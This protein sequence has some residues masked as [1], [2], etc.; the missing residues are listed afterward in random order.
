[1]ARTFL[2]P[3]DFNKNE[4]RN[5]R[6]QNLSTAPSSPVTGQL[7][8]DTDDNKG[9]MWNGTSW[10]SMLEGGAAGI[11]TTIVDVKGDLIVATGADAVSRL[12]VGAD[13][14]I[15]MADAAAG[16]G[17]KWVAPTTTPAAIG[18]QAGGTGDTFTR[19]DHVHATGASTPSTQAF[20]D[21]AAIGSGPA[22]SMTDHKHA[23][24][25]HALATH[26]EMLATADLT[27][28]PRVAALS[29]SS[30]LITNLLDPVSAQD[31]ATKNYVDAI[32][33]GLNWKDSVRAATTGPI[34]LSTG[35]NSADVIDGV[36]LANGDRVLVKDQAAGA[37]NGVYIVS[38][39]PARAT[40]MDVAGEILQAAVWVEEG[41]TN[42]DT[43]WVNTTNAPITLGTTATVWAQFTGL[44]DI[45]AGTGLTKTASTLNVVAGTGIVA[46]ADDIAVLRTDANGRVPLKF[47]ATFGDGAATSYNIDHNLNSLDVLV[48]VWQVSDGV[49]VEPDITRSTV[50]R[51]ILA[52]TTA[53]T[54][55]QYRVCVYG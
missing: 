35:L 11:P 31:A 54:S 39:S 51:V 14:T 38:A 52:F 25:A 24:P 29:M 9:Y 13:D 5:A 4:I 18:T 41:T 36:T 1:M 34:T 27:D 53:P 19:G 16:T 7:Y 55:N 32:A 10:V 48:Q 43:G 30:Q 20:G 15:L 23:M 37:E 21:A 49:Q 26:Q 28:W 33:S 44:G 42:A 17:V 50:N 3:V 47:A 22:A 8:Y 45:T 46:N 2:I 6:V 40:D 12:A